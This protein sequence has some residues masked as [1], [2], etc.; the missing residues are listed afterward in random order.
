M[1]SR[2]VATVVPAVPG[3]TWFG[4]QFYA[5]GSSRDTAFVMQIH[6]EGVARSESKETWADA[7][8]PKGMTGLPDKASSFSLPVDS[9]G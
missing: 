3:A 2:R 6:S 9:V 5:Y 7:T 8:F 1:V 4:T